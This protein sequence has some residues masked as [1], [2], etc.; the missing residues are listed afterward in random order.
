MY[1]LNIKLCVLIENIHME[2][3]ISQTFNIGPSFDF[4]K[5]REIIMKKM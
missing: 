1:F 4:M 2:G 5:S 3:N